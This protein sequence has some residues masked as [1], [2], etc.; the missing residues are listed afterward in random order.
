MLDTI[1]QQEIT[2]QND[3]DHGIEYDDVAYTAHFFHTLMLKRGKI[4]TNNGW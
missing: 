2:R 1:N 4:G 3:F